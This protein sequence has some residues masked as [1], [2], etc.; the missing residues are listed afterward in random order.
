[1]NQEEE[2]NPRVNQRKRNKREAKQ[3][4]QAKAKAKK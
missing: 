2:A 1:M 3:Y 4:K